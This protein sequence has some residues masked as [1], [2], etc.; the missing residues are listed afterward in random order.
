MTQSQCRLAPPGSRAALG[1]WDLTALMIN[2]TI[3]A[4][5]LGLPGRVYALVGIWG[6]PLLAAGGLLMALVAACF[7]QAGSRFTRS[8]G[9]YLFVYE[10]FGADAGFAMGWLS[11]VSRLFAFAAISNLAAGYANALWPPLAVGPWHMLG[12]TA[13]TLALAAPVYRGVALSAWASNLFTL[14][15]LTLLL[16]FVALAIPTFA[17]HGVALTPVP[18]PSHWAPALLML[19]FALTGLEATAISNGDMRNPARDIPFA[20]AV[21][22]VTVVAIY[23]AVLLASA[24][25]VPSLA[26][27]TRPIFDGAIL[28]VGPAGGAGAV[29]GGVICMAGVLFVILFNTPREIQALAVNNQLPRALAQSHSRWHTPTRAIATFAVLAWALALSSSFQGALAAATLTRLIMYAATAA[30]LIR[31]RRQGFSET[32]SPLILRGSTGVP[33]AVLLICGAVIAQSTRAEFV[34]LAMALLPAL[35]VLALV[36]RPNSK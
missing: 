32:P 16:G 10:A 3:G 12:I 25:L 23:G 29:L 22:I 2:A 18:P 14:C 21:G 30:S 11:V 5:I 17:R 31:L 13:L 8:G 1:R 33:I 7:A 9:P 15:K 34:V 4:G 28:A 24:A 26:G 27:S 19:L 20:L 36:P 6:V 35:L